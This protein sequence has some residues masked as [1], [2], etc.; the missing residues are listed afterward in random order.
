MKYIHLPGSAGTR[1]PPDASVNADHYLYVPDER[2]PVSPKTALHFHDLLEDAVAKADE[3]TGN[4]RQPSIPAH[5]PTTIRDIDLDLDVH[6]EDDIV[7]VV[8]STSP[9]AQGQAS[10]ETVTYRRSTVRLIA[11]ASLATGVLAAVGVFL[12]LRQ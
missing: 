7:D 1:T 12:A 5:A 3:V 8:A 2:N 10:N 4:T 6:L 11:L 9:P